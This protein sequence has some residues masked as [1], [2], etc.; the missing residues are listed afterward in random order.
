[1]EAKTFEMCYTKRI[2]VK[3]ELKRNHDDIT[4]EDGT[5]NTSVQVSDQEKDRFTELAKRVTPILQ[6]IFVDSWNAQ[7]ARY[8]EVEVSKTLA[9]KAKELMMEK[10]AEETQ[11]EI[12]SESS[13]SA[14]KIKDLIADAVK[15]ATSKQQGEIQKLSATIK[16]SNTKDSNPKNSN[17]GAPLQRTKKTQRAPSTKKKE[18]KQGEKSD[19]PKRK[20]RENSPGR[21]GRDSPK[22]KKQSN[23][24]SGKKQSRQ[25]SSNSQRPTS[26]R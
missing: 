6:V 24:Q 22:G 8:R 17:R 16:R 4:Q 3:H 5:Q 18:G 19:P 15:K 1:M 11:M 20:E 23:K 9:K 26:R 7:I 2:D 12:D 25:N 13:I 14:T 10:K 21:K